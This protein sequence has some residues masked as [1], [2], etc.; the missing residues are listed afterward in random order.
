MADIDEEFI[1]HFAPGKLIRELIMRIDGSDIPATLRDINRA[2]L[3]GQ[4]SINYSNGTAASA[5]FR[6]RQK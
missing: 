3:S 5:E 4:L 2:K 6:V 1:S